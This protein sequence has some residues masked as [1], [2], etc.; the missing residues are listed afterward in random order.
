MKSIIIHITTYIASILI[1]LFSVNAKAESPSFT[2]LGAEYVAS[3]SFEASRG[4]LSADLDSSGFAVN[5]SVELGVFFIQA[6]RLELDND[7]ILGIESDSSFTSIGLGLTFELPQTQVYGLVRAQQ[8][9]LAIRG[10][11]FDDDVDG[12]V[13]GFEVG[14]RVNLTNRF[15]L[16]AYLG[17]P[18]SDA[19]TSFG[20]GGQFFVT[21]NIGITLN[22]NS[23][24]AEEEDI[25]A[26]FDTSSVGVRFTF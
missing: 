6:S 26:S 25:S 18:S 3:G 7:D 1:L 19:G 24:E 10:G 11:G 5:G 4:S 14:A 22:F 17:R 16:N 12:S 2:Y 9:E 21:D 23:I 8:A 15:E 13:A 20:V